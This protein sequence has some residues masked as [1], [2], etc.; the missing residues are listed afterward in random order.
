MQFPAIN[1]QTKLFSSQE[2]TQEKTRFFA[3]SFLW[4]FLP[5]PHFTKVRHF[6]A[7]QLPPCLDREPCALGSMLTSPKCPNWYYVQNCSAA[8]EVVRLSVSSPYGFFLVSLGHANRKV[9]HAA[10][11]MLILMTFCAAF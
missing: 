4:A 2:L 10:K 5:G 9:P 11:S 3:N 7:R 1:S 6:L 8:A